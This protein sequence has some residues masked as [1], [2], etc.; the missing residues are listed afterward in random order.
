MWLLKDKLYWCAGP[1]IVAA[2]LLIML[3][4]SSGNISCYTSIKGIVR[5]ADYVEIPNFMVAHDSYVQS[6]FAFMISSFNTI[7]V[8]MVASS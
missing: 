7:F 3:F 2:C 8:V 5:T 6:Y 4:D 1:G